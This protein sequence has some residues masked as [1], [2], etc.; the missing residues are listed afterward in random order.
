MN[1][2]RIE[3]FKLISFLMSGSRIKLLSVVGARPQFMKATMLSKEID[4]S[5]DFEE[6]LVHKGNII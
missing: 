4:K 6:V 1:F 2:F 3:F 5:E